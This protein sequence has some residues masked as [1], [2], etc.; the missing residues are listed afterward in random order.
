MWHHEN[1]RMNYLPFFRRKVFAVAS[2][3]AGKEQEDRAFIQEQ[4]ITG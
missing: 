2:Y 4:F 1:V 3:H